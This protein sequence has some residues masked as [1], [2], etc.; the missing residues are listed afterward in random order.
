MVVKGS[1]YFHNDKE[2]ILLPPGVEPP[3]GYV[4]GKLLSQETRTKMSNAQK[5]HLP[6]NTGKTAYTNGKDLIYLTEEDEIP[7]GFVKGGKPLNESIKAEVVEKRHQTCFER[8]GDRNYNNTEKNLKTLTKTFGSLEAAR[9]HMVKAQHESNLKK[10]GV[11][12]TASLQWVKDKA[13]KTRRKKYGVTNFFQNPEVLKKA[14]TNAQTK[15]AKEKRNNTNIERYGYINPGLSP[16]IIQK[17][18][19]TVQEKYGV[20]FACMR[21]EVNVKGS[22]SK[23]NK[24]FESL[25]N[26]LNIVS[27][28]REFCVQRY[29]F[30]F[31]V[32]N[33]L[34][35][36]NPSPTHNSTWSVHKKDPISKDYHKNKT[37]A[38]NKYGYRC[39][40][41]WDW[42]NKEKIAQ[43][44]ASKETLYAR[45]LQIKEVS[46]Q[47]CNEFL[48]KYH[49]Q[50][51]CQ[52]Q[53]VRL[54]LYY[55]NELVQIMTFG[56]PRYNKKYEWELLRLCTNYKYRVVGGSEK[57]FKYFV[58]K[59]NPQSIIS[60]C[61]NSKFIG[62]VYIKLG[63]KLINDHVVSKHWYNIKTQKHFTDNL[64]RQRGVDQLL[65]T[66]FG[67]GTSNEEL[68]KELN[69]V[70]IYDAG[71]STYV[72][73]K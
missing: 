56:K 8:Y 60:Y 6:P 11:E 1:K 35:E 49:F 33:T 34:I 19:N 13:D 27:Y 24:F 23:P 15:E 43:S 40:H 12:T 73:I 58:T 69:F 48:Q 70:E 44:L 66:N 30:D 41:V 31:K 4:P 52:N 10:Y 37:L 51:T 47:T 29:L 20:P 46:K 62:D 32:D 21:P 64:V 53:T 68:L 72:W 7:E 22:N 36:I 45:K 16:E 39:I 55:N 71:Q 65:G 25:L 5:G 26:E 38:A 3:E 17:V 9:K 54:G 2:T 63:F 67:K 42:D 14:M 59:Y 18:S 57:L 28:E 61:D 50:N